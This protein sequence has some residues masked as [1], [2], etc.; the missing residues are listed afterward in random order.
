M[1]TIMTPYDSMPQ[2]NRQSIR[3]GKS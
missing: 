3:T 2:W 1:K